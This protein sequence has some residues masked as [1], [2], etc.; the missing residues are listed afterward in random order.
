MTIVFVDE[1]SAPGWEYAAQAGLGALRRAA[2]EN[3]DSP[4]K[5]LAISG[6]KGILWKTDLGVVYESF[7]QIVRTA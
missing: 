6:A 5:R 7:T 4:E 3:A 2:V 1:F